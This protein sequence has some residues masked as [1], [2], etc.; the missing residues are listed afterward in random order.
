MKKFIFALCAGALVLTGCSTYQYSARQAAINRQDIQATPSVVDV[1]A[2]FTKRIEVTSGWHAIKDDAM[3]E[4]RYMAITQNK[5]DLVVDPIF[6]IEYRP[7]AISNKFK[8]TLIGFAGYY[9]N[10]RTQKED[11]EAISQFSREDIEKYLILHNPAVLNYMNN[12]EQVVNI[13]HNEGQKAC[14]KP[15]E[16]PKAAEPKAAKGKK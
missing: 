1:R 4:C 9:T 14:D 3:N 16:E 13:Y 10:S 2:D 12:R 15:A 7:M 11:L 6:K 8:A 5:I